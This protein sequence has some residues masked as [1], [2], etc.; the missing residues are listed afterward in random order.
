MYFF[1]EQK[2]LVSEKEIPGVYEFVDGHHHQIIKIFKN[3]NYEK[4]YRKNGQEVFNYK[5]NW[6]IPVDGGRGI[7]FTGYK[8]G[9]F[10]IGWHNIPDGQ[11][12]ASRSADIYKW[13]GCIY[14]PFHPDYEFAFKKCQ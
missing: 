7:E 3:K 1:R 5:G 9:H 2:S 12:L 13:N 14:I 6:D 11:E 10:P 8:I 4:I